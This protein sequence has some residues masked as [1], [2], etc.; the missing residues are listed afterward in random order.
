MYHTLKF[1]ERLVNA[2]L[3][4]SLSLLYHHQSSAVFHAP[5]I[6]RRQCNAMQKKRGKKKEIC[7]QK[8]HQKAKRQSQCIAHSL[9][10]KKSLSI[11]HH[12]PSLFV[13]RAMPCYAL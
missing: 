2:H 9:S 6:K 5:I 7:S 12:D 8:C 3:M 10:S 13:I 4:L 1:P 11:I